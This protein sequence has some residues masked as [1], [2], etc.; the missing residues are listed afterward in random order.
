[1][2]LF[3]G[4][5]ALFVTQ[6]D[7][8]SFKLFPSKYFIK[9]LIEPKIELELKYCRYPGRTIPPLN[10][11]GFIG[12]TLDPKEM[13]YSWTTHSTPTGFCIETHFISDPQLRYARTTINTQSR[14]ISIELAPAHQDQ[15]ISIDPLIQPIGSLLLI[16]LAHLTNG[17]L[18]HASGIQ[19]LDKQGHIFTA[20]SGTGKSTMAKLWKETGACV[21]NDDRLWMH[22]IED[23]WHMF[24]TPMVFYAQEPLMAPVNNIFLIKQSPYNYLNSATG[25]NAQMRVMSNCIQ[26]FYN[27]EMTNNHLM[28]VLDFTSKAKI[29]ECGFM[30]NRKIIEEIRELTR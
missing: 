14:Q 23:Q 4:P 6:T 26:H 29:Y 7:N 22:Q 18:I 21:I 27:K 16:Y 19:D 1:M 9:P 12:E 10:K 11:T 8:I 30:P 24:S 17:F 3:L 5:V 2:Q 15:E 20:V 13:P 25:L 28:S